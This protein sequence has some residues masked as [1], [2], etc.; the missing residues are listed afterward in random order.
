MIVYHPG[1]GTYMDWNE[2]VLIDTDEEVTD[3]NVAEL[4]AERG[5]IP[6]GEKFTVV[7]GNPS[8]GLRFF[9][10]FY[11]WEAGLTWASNQDEDWYL[12]DLETPA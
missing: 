4:A 10:P 8:E 9:G 7:L 12:T 5:S 3:E 1:T 6:T 2:V 11:D